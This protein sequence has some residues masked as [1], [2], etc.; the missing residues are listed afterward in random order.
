MCLVDLVDV[1]SVWLC[2]VDL[3]DVFSGSGR[4]V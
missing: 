4:C 3:V 1:F 2:L